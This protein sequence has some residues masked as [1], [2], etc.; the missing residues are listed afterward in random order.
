[1]PNP[2]AGDV[3]VNR[4]LTNI[5][6]AYMQ[7]AEG[8]VADRVFPNIPVQ[9]ESDKYFR[10]D[11]SDFWRNQYKKRAI[12]SESAGGGWK[13][14]SSPTYFCDVWALHKDIDDRIRANEDSPL[15][16]DR[17]A[18]LW[19]AQQ[20][21]IA[22]EVEW[23]STFLTTSVWTGIDGTNGDI[24]GVASS[25]STNQV[26]QWNDASSTPIEDVK[27]KA[28][29]IQLLTGFRPNKL[30]LGRQVWDALSDHPDIVDRI[31]YSGGV[32]PSTPAK[33][34]KQAVAA[35][36]EVDEILVADGIQ[37]T[38][39]E[40]PA[41]ETSMTTAFIAGKVALLVY[42]NP[43]PSILMPSGGYTFSWTGYLGAGAMGQRTKKMRVEL[44]N[45]DRVEGEMAY[46]QKLVCSDCGIFWTSIVA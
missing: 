42:A 18:A 25:P 5:S 3:H 23:A 4:P 26:L 10:Y 12:S 46:D 1:M 6:I 33:V 27:A 35:L 43:A 2:T 11:R 31:K 41:F 37:V 45:S 39:E 22:R 15:S 40:N 14:D 30:V 7:S 17:D 28:T 24:T 19:L 9:K 34:T 21:M 29:L 13:V 36:M 32:S 16:M 44:K 38:S 20:G 8:F